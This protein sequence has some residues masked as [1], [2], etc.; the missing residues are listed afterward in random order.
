MLSG[1][2]ARSP[3]TFSISYCCILFSLKFG[4]QSDSDNGSAECGKGTS[5]FVKLCRNSYDSPVVQDTDNCCIPP[6]IGG[7]V[8]VAVIMG[9]DTAQCRTDV[10]STGVTTGRGMQVN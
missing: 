1:S 4:C 10:R 9:V 2:L 6:I 8:R 3:L 7:V 5:S